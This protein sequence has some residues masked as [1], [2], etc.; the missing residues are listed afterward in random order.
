MII[1]I[2][3]KTWFIHLV[4]M[5]ARGQLHYSDLNIFTL[6]QPLCR[7]LTEN[8]LP[9]IRAVQGTVK[10][11]WKNDGNFH[12][13]HHPT[14]HRCLYRK[15][16]TYEDFGAKS[17]Y[18]RQGSVIKSHSKLWDVITYP[19]LRYLL[20]TPKSSYRCPSLYSGQPIKQAI[21]SANPRPCLT[22]SHR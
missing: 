10:D 6:F 15:Q 1:Y 19:C 7:V 20:L 17:R 21:T 13:P 16:Y 5:Q 11:L 3:S 22:V 8:N 14:V 4:Y 9:V 18:L 12:R 2:P